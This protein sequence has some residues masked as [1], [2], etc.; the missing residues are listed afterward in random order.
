MV[1]ENKQIFEYI[2]V[3]LELRSD[4][5]IIINRKH[6][7]ERISSITLT[8]DDRKNPNC[9]LSEIEVNMQER[10][11]GKPYCGAGMARPESAFLFV[12]QE[13]KALNFP[14]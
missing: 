12:S 13:Q 11:L 2:G 7:I 8:K 4:F 5:P 9:K 6:Y 3:K 1:S 14:T 10:I